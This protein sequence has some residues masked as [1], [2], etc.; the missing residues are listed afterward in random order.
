M[1]SYKEASKRFNQAGSG[2][3]GLELSTFQDWVVKNVCRYYFEL[4][5]ILKDRPNVTPWY[6]NEQ[7]DEQEDDTCLQTIDKKKIQQA[8][9][10]Q[11]FFLAMTP[12]IQ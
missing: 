6:T 2:F 8:K 4:D 1:A 10:S 3:E 9:R 12:M 5:P 7:E 11:S